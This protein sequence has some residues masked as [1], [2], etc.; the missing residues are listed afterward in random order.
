[1][2]KWFSTFIHVAPADYEI[3]LEKL[4]GKGF[5]P[6]K[7]SQ[8]SSIVMS[9]EKSE[10]KKYRYVLDVQP[11]PQSDYVPTYEEFGWELC[12]RM[13]NTYFWRM[14]YTD[15]RPESF[16]DSAAFEERN[17]RFATA[18]LLSLIPFLAAAIILTI[19][20]FQLRTSLTARL[21]SVR[22]WNG[23]V[24]RSVAVSLMGD[25]ENFPE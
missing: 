6:K 25:A 20:F 5:H 12:G 1:M 15:I 3:W 16:S 4:A 13:A 22:T 7:V 8:W 18:V 11:V 9:F 23:A 19:S 17:K 21:H 24:L 14:E 2:L 10:P